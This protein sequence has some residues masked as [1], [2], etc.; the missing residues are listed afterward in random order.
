MSFIS[1]SCYMSTM[2]Q[3]ESSFHYSD[4]ETEPGR[5]SSYYLENHPSLCQ[6]ER[7]SWRVS[8]WQINAW[9][10][11]DTYHSHWW[12]IGWCQFYGL[13]Y[14]NGAKSGILPY[15]QEI[16]EPEIFGV[17]YSYYN[18]RSM[19]LFSFLHSQPPFLNFHFRGLQYSNRLS[20]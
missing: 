2:N 20:L 5:Q 1:Q 14:Y 19:M 13:T 16:G 12:L 15:A 10:K 4:S 17:Y 9:P 6:R 8:H 11:R 18:L 7:E 3:Q